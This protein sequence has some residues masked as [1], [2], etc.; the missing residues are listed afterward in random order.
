VRSRR[1]S[2]RGRRPLKLIVRFPVNPYHYVVSLRLQH[3]S[4]DLAEAT[5][6][7]GLSPKWCWKAGTPRMTPRGGALPG[8]YRESY[9]T[10]PLLGGAKVLSTDVSLADSLAGILIQ[11]APQR[12]F[13]AAI[14]DSGGSGECFVGLFASENFGIELSATLMRGFS[15]VGLNL[16]I[17]AYP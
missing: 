3:P 2:G 16:A 11:V 17:D 6:R 1:L 15:D 7:F 8:T 4:I 9:W 5:I 13:L 10:A 12:E 14:R